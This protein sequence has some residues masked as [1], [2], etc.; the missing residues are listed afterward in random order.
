MHFE[1]MRRFRNWKRF[2]QKVALAQCDTTTVQPKNLIFR[3]NAL[4]NHIRSK[5]T[6]QLDNRLD[7]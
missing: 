7:H 6:R 4:G 5:A 2:A 3:L 1:P